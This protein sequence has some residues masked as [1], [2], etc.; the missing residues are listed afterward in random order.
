MIYVILGLVVWSI[1]SI[2]FFYRNMGRKNSKDKWYDYPLLLPFLVI[3]TIAGWI[4]TL[5]GWNK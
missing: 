4:S 5:F 2:W 1:I 3:V